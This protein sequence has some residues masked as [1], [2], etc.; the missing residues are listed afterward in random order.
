MTNDKVNNERNKA[1]NFTIVLLHVEMIKKTHAYDSDMFELVNTQ[2]PPTH[3]TR[4]SLAL[5]YSS[6]YHDILDEPE[7]ACRLAKQVFFL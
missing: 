1:Y 7:R 3:P 2:L 5:S 4:L 6:F